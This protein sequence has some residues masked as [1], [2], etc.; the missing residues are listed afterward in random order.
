M[1][2]HVEAAARWS[3]AAGVV[4]PDQDIPV[5]SDSFKTE[6]RAARTVEVMAPTFS[7]IGLAVADMAASLSFYRRLGLPFPAGAE[8]EPHVEVTVSGGIRLMWDTHASIR[9]FDPD[10]EPG[11]PSGG[12]AFRC[13]DAGEV[14][15]LHADLV[16]A[17]Y[18]SVQEPWDAPW[19]QRYAQVRDPDDNVVDLFAQLTSPQ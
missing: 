17:G 7:A 12:W 11:P 19:G 3:G 8:D 1:A 5:P 16:A 2:R 4:R 13:A 14:E 10:F 6:R 18:P 9:S 15:K